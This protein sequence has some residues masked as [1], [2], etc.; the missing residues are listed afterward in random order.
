MKK[1]NIALIIVVVLLFCAS[2]FLSY[3]CASC[4]CSSMC[5]PKGGDGI[6]TCKNC[7]KSITNKYMLGFCERCYEGFYDYNRKDGF[8]D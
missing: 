3:T 2:F 6:K 7:G 8:Y 4:V 1:P 5:E